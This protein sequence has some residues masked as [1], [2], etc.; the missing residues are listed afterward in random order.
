MKAPYTFTQLYKKEEIPEEAVYTNYSMQ[1]YYN[2]YEADIDLLQIVSIVQNHFNKQKLP[3]YT[4]AL[5]YA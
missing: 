1:E 4:L 2:N 5:V 3:T